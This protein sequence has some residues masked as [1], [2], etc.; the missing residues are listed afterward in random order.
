MDHGI[1][2]ITAKPFKIQ[3][4][5][6]NTFNINFNGRFKFSFPIYLNLDGQIISLN[7]DNLFIL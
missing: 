2:L 4:E 1:Y 5:F 7:C 3:W 6:Q